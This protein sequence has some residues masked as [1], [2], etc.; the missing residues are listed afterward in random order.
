MAAISAYSS[1]YPAV[2]P[3]LPGC[4]LPVILNAFQKA[5]R[6]FCQD[7][8][9]WREALDP[10]PMT[11][12]QKDYILAHPYA[13][14]IHRLL[15]VAVNGRVLGSREYTLEDED[16]L[17]LADT[18]IPVEDSDHRVLR[19]AAAGAATLS[20]WTP[21]VDGSFALDVDEWSYA[22]GGLDF[23]Q[24]A[25]MDDVALV[26]QTA[27]RHAT[28]LH[29]FYAQWTSSCFVFWVS[30]GTLGEITAGSAGT[31]IAGAS[32][33]NATASLSAPMLQATVVF[34]PNVAADAMPDWFLDRYSEALIARVLADLLGQERKKWSSPSMS[35]RYEAEYRRWWNRA[36]VEN[37]VQQKSTVWGFY[38]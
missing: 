10:L 13:A 14:S 15:S 29:T 21:I 25:D 24:C 27:V 37:H 11:D 3:S 34:R 30:S 36:K 26:I 19:C 32:H 28:E 35:A 4:D 6:Q 38:A 23:A 18:A 2:V 16:T 8:E 1:L 5:G 12:W 22:V 31:D 33:L 7:T 20:D 17:R 9:T